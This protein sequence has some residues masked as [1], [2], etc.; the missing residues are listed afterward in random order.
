M[1]DKWLCC[2]HDEATPQIVPLDRVVA[3]YFNGTDDFPY[4]IV[5]DARGTNLD[6]PP[7]SFYA[8]S[9]RSVSVEVASNWLRDETEHLIAA[10]KGDAK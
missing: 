4:E 7:W 10:A 5:V 9:P 2:W 8:R 1:N 6:S 3:I